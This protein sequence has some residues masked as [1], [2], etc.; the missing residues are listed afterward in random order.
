VV[1]VVVLPVA[2]WDSHWLGVF[3]KIEKEMAS[4]SVQFMGLW[5]REILLGTFRRLGDAMW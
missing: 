5:L 3:C 4:I 1:V 2:V